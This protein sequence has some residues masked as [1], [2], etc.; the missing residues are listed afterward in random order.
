MN[1]IAVGS[2]FL[3]KTVLPVEAVANVSL[4]LAPGQD[5]DEIAPEVERLLSA[6]APAGAELEIEVLGSSSA[7]A[8]LARFARS[9]SSGSTR[10]SVSWAGGRR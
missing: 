8:R 10:S 2:P 5:P 6:A 1:G 4:R 7:G 3:Q 9:C